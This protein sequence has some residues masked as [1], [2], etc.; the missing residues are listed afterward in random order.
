MILESDD[1]EPDVSEKEQMKQ[2]VSEIEKI[3]TKCPECGSDKL[4][5]DHER[6][7]I[8]CGACGL[9]ID[10]SIMDMGPEWRALIMSSVI[11]GH[12][13]EHQ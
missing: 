1:I 13:W 2:D 9:V 10:D 3:E 6:G 11:K 8:V 4:I 12:G 5:N 7:E